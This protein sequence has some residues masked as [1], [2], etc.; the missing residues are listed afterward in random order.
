[1]LRELIER[2]GYRIQLF[3]AER[4]GESLG[5][6]SDPWPIRENESPRQM[7]MRYLQVW[8]GGIIIL[9]F[10]SRIII[11]HAPNSSFIVSVVVAI[12]GL[13]WTFIGVAVW[14]AE[15]SAKKQRT[16]DSDA[17]HLTNRSS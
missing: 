15:W 1:M 12:L 4:R 10:V 6:G 9:V 7:V 3:L 2:F 14:L 17:N 13:G 8:L 16:V 5:A 11:S